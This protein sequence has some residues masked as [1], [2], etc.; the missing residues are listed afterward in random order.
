MSLELN[1][2]R[3]SSFWQK[4]FSLLSIVSY[5][6]F[7]V[8]LSF[9]CAWWIVCHV[10]VF[11]LCMVKLSVMFCFL[12]VHGELSVMSCF[13]S[14]WWNCLSCS[15]FLSVNGELSVMF[16]FLSVHGELSVTFC[17]F[18]CVWWIVCHVLFFCLCMV[19]CLSCSVFLSVYG[20]LSVMFC[21]FVCAWWTVC[22]VLV[23]FVC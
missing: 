15:G 18:V 21:F 20:E 14:A 8:F 17:F 9:V 22:Y 2:F 10:L 12:S 5:F 19:N 1:H 7:K 3:K 23:V 6:S 16:C 13:L 4:T 11:C